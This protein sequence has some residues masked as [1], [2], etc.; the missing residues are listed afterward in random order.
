MQEGVKVPMSLIMS[1]QAV[2]V[3]LACFAWDYSFRHKTFI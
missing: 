2:V 3:S 1:E